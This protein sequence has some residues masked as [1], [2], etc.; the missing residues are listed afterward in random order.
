A[1]IERN[2]DSGA[3]G[4]SHSVEYQ[5][6]TTYRELL[7]YARLAGRYDRTFFLHLRSSS[8][9][10]ELDG[11][12]EAVGIARE[13]GVRLHIGHLHSTG[14]T[15]QM[16]EAL[17]RIGAANATGCRITACVYPYS[18][19]ATYLGSTRFSGDWQRRYGLTY[20]DLVVVGTGER[21]TRE[22]FAALRRQ[23]GVLVA[24]P[25][26]TM[27]LATTADLAL[28]EDFGMIGSDGGIQRDRAANNHP[29]GA[30]CFATA[31]RHG[32]SIGLPLEKILEKVTALPRSLVLPALRDRGVLAEGFAAD[33]VIFDPRTINGAATTANPNQYSKGVDCVIVNG[34][35]AYRGGAL[36]SQRGSPVRMPAP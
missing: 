3:L 25:E 26:G 35:I 28:Q 12:D 17:R 33:L 32:L 2:L 21:L 8:R 18:Y 31:I 22:S 30:G 9:E 34:E 5:P 13:T 7:E 14:G 24:V 16:A 4:V 23:P 15:F 1:A 19:W 11:V 10:R 29:R 20:G 6:A 27:P 36:V